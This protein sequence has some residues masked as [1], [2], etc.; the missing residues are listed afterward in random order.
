MPVLHGL[1]KTTPI[2]VGGFGDTDCN[3]DFSVGLMRFADSIG[4][5]YLAWTW[6]TAQHYGGCSNALLDA[7][8]GKSATDGYYSGRPSGFGT[9]GRIHFRSLHLH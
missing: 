8:S 7:G 4:M 5:S 3:S 1:A 9:G 2:I 6:N